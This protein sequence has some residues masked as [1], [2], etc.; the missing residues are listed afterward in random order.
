LNKVATKSALDRHAAF[1][2]HFG[3]PSLLVKS[4]SHLLKIQQLCLKIRVCSYR[5][6]V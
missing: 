1:D 4:V 2:T 5:S 3:R 6:H